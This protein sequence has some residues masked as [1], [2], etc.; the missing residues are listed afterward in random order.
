MKAAQSKG[1]I[2]DLIASLAFFP[3]IVSKEDT[4]A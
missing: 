3:S 4:W 1:I 2:L